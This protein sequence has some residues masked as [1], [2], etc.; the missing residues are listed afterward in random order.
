MRARV[1]VCPHVCVHT[2]VCVCVCVF[3]CACVY[4]CVCVLVVELWMESLV[5]HCHGGLLCGL[6]CIPRLRSLHLIHVVVSCPACCVQFLS[7]FASE[8]PAPRDS[9]DEDSSS[10]EDD[11]AHDSTSERDS[12]SDEVFH[13]QPTRRSSRLRKQRVVM[14]VGHEETPTPAMTRRR[15]ATA[16]SRNDTGGSRRIP[17]SRP[18]SRR[19]SR[20]RFRRVRV[21]VCVC[22]CWVLCVVC[23]VLLHGAELWSCGLVVLALMWCG[24]GEQRHFDS[25]SSSSG[26]SSGSEA[27]FARYQRRR[28][29]RERNAIQYA[30]SRLSLFGCSCV[31]RPAQ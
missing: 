21:C 4:V 20:R 5:L 9:A 12:S 23:W 7:E 19:R 11:A 25:S 15:S 22:L 10:V 31:P 1:C 3:P 29:T 16:P 2:C 24:V 18:R 14:N 30:R 13:P 8:H 27:D 17:A 6:C 28:H 26:D